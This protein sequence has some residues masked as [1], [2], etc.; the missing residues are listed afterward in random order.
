MKRLDLLVKGTPTV[1]AFTLVETLVAIM[2]LTICVVGPFQVAQGVLA[3]AYV[4]RDKLIASAIAQEGMEYLRAIRDSNYLYNIHTSSTLSWLSGFD[5]N[6]GPNCY[7]NTCVIDTSQYP[8]AVPF[9]AGNSIIAC[10]DSTCSTR[11]LYLSSSNIYNQQTSGVRTRFTRTIK[12]VQISATETQ[13]TV[14]VSWV[15]HANY[16]V[17]LVENIQNWL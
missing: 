5:G 10:S 4:S 7:S 16:S 1:T 3:T 12:L 15:G 17:T 9:Q 14:T 6:N 2:V 8:A 13:V 11:P